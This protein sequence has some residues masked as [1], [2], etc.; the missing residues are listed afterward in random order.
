MNI[1]TAVTYFLKFIQRRIAG[2]KWVVRNLANL[3]PNGR[4]GAPVWKYIVNVQTAYPTSWGWPVVE[5][6]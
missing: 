4:L 2:N 3:N 1:P 5:V 6:R